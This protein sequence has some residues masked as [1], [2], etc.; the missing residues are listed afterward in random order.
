MLNVK[1]EKMFQGN[2]SSIRLDAHLGGVICWTCCFTDGAIKNRSGISV[3]DQT[4]VD[5]WA[6]QCTISGGLGN[7]VINGLITTG[8][9]ITGASITTNG[10]MTGYRLSN[11]GTSG[12][13][14]NTNSSTFL[15]CL[16]FSCF[17]GN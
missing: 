14:Q 5:T 12:S 17:Y 13:P 6:P 9:N 16:V 7:T 3:G 15:Y 1:S 11:T 8:G 10:A 2:N 4:G